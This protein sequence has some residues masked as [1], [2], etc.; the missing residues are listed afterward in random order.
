M[1]DKPVLVYPPH[2]VPWSARF[3]TIDAAWR[4]ILAL[5]RRRDNP[6]N[7]AKMEAEGWEVV[8]TGAKS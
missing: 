4:R 5:K 2:R 8:T 6:A 1:R 7:R 3:T